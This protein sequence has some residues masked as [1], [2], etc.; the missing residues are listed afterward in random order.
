M[1]DAGP[2][3]RALATR[4]LALALL[5]WLTLGE[6]RIF[7]R[8]L[9]SPGEDRDFVLGAMQGILEG[10]PVF[11]AW[12]QRLLGP[13]AVWLLEHAGLSRLLALRLLFALGLFA[14][15]VLLYALARAR[16]ASLGGA[17][18]LVAGFGFAHLLLAYDLEYPWDAIDVLLFMAFGSWAAQRGPLIALVPLLLVGSF[19]HETIL[20]V[21]LWLLLA[22]PGRAR[23]V[24]A[25]TAVAIGALIYGLREALYVSAPPEAVR[26]RAEA[27]LPL[28]GN[29]VHIVHNLRQLFMANWL[30]GRSFISLSFFGA[31]AV[32]VWLVRSGRERVAGLWSLCV[33][34][35]VACFGY[36][37]ETRLY[38]PLLAFWFAY[39]ASERR[40]LP[41]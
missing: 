16:G 26:Q 7:D 25:A 27:V 32:C 40:A 17:A 1:S 20:Y 28:L 6:W 8:L 15:N 35:A 31:V 30:H 9:F 18:A 24:G 29:P 12:Q 2:A 22:G 41:G 38:L 33:L 34:A 19:N 23:V 39:T 11:E 5:A 21:P 13:G 14:A 4:C 37:N 10:R 3:A 36:T